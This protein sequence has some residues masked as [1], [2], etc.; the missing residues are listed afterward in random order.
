MVL[1]I[2]VQRQDIECYRLPIN[3]K[4]HQYIVVSVVLS[5]IIIW[6]LLGNFGGAQF[7]ASQEL[8]AKRFDDNHIMISVPAKKKFR[9]NHAKGL[10]KQNEILFQKVLDE[11]GLSE[12]GVTYQLD[13]ET[14]T[15][16][17]QP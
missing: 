1:P 7:S 16:Y 17:K 12:K 4:S 2:A 11:S 6:F 10:D 9:E 13:L 8:S 14:W 3:M 5:V 15:V